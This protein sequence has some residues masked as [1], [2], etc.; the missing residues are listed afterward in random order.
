VSAI[1]T[2]SN[3]GV[4]AN[5]FNRRRGTATGIASAGIGVGTMLLV[6]AAEYITT[7]AGWRAAYIFLALVVALTVPAIT[8]FF[9][10][11]RPEDMGLQPDGATA[12][13]AP[14]S[15]RPVPQMRVVDKAWA[16]RNWT[17]RAAVGTRAFWLLFFGFMFSTWSHQ[18]IMIH[19]VAYLSDRG[20][21]PM[22]GAMLVGLVG[23]AASLGKVFWGW[24]SDRI[25]REGAYTLGM[26][27]VFFGIIFLG[28]VTDA[29]RE[30]LLYAYALF[31]GIG[32]GVF[33]PMSSAISADLFQGRS[34][35]SIYGLLWVGSGA[36][37]SLGPWLC[38]ALFD[39]T[40]AYTL[41][42]AVSLVAAVASVAAFWLAAPRKVRQV[43]GVAARAQ[44][45][46]QALA[47]GR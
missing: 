4:L 31:F 28:L 15:G 5:W 20:F 30:S 47:Q 42:F 45:T 25:G 41:S 10:R 14:G 36:G 6:P 7:V 22:L 43:P 39:A 27:C 29:S 24:L 1:G 33:S 12:S 17:V 37:S 46:R 40:G 21:E 38:A 26:A 34:F 18:P 32:Y 13:R 44:R 8:F 19:Q 3:L 9:Q 2:T 16:A 23:L 11:H 35:A